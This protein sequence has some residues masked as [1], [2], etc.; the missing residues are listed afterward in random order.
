MG[1]GSSFCTNKNCNTKHRSAETVTILNK[2][3]YVVKVGE[4]SISLAFIKPSIS[5]S[6]LDEE[7]VNLWS[8]SFKTLKQWSRT[9]RL[10]KAALE[11]KGVAT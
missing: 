5:I 9:F 6:G 11:T 8:Q 10:T 7:I 2:H 1:Q 3:L 4:K